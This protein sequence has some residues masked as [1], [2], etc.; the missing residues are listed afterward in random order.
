M[1][2]KIISFEP[3]TI[4]TIDGG[5]YDWVDK[6]LDLSTNTNRGFNK[7]PVIWLGTERAFQI[8]NNKEL[9]GEDDRLKL[10]IITVNRESITKD[11]TFKGAFQAHLYETD[12]PKGSVVT[13]YRRLKQE[14]TRNIINADTFRTL[15]NGSETGPQNRSESAP[16]T[17]SPVYQEISIPV[18]TYI[19]V[20]YSITL[21]TEYQ[22][23][24]NDLVAPFIAKTGQINSFFFEKDNYRYEAFVQP[25][26]TENKNIK[27][28]GEDE[29]MFET[30][31]QIK[32]LGYL[33]G[34]GVNR[35]RPK[36]T[37]RENIV[38]IRIANE[39]VVLADEVPWKEEEK[40]KEYLPR[41]WLDMG[42]FTVDK[43]NNPSY[44]EN[45][46]E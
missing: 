36:V 29:R 9:R 39:R 25:D 5:L 3:S 33:I 40:E 31:V 2:D 1:P 38:K 18:P 42:T 45:E 37:I 21:R 8:K 32:V 19:N 4:E 34:E 20:M 43:A 12:D 11:P 14:K 10:P 16:P 23:Q 44:G 24:M 35:E 7:V 17:S 15:S 22:Q 30:T 46:D 28:M 13:I 26:F 41:Y 27:D 6:T